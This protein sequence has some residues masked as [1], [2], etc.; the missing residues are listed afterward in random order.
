MV[1]E[2][3]IGSR[4]LSG[5]GRDQTHIYQILKLG[6]FFFM[7]ILWWGLFGLILFLLFLIE[8]KGLFFGIEGYAFSNLVNS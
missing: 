3:V 6:V 2:K 7:F 8:G 4:L 1:W 5:R